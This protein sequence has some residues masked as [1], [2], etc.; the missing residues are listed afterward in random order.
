MGRAW[1]IREALEHDPGEP[2]PPLSGDLRTDVVIVGGGFTGLWTA[3]FL[4]EAEPG[5]RTAILEQDI[6][7]GGPSGRN[8]GFVTGWWD[9]LPGLVDL[10][11]ERGALAACRAL[12]S[13]VA[14]VGLWCER[15]GVD[16]WY[17]R[18]GYIT[19]ACAPGQEG[20]ADASVR[21]ANALGARDELTPMSAEEVRARCASPVF[22]SGV[23]M[24]DG[25][26]VQPARLARGLRRVALES[27]VRIFEGTP[28]RR[29][30]AGPPARA[31]TPYG[32]VT[33]DRAVVAVGAWAAAWPAFRR[34]L[35]TWTSFIVLTAPAPER[36]AA[37]G[38]TGGECITDA[39]TTVQYFRTTPDGRIAFGGGG[40]RVA[41]PRRPGLRWSRDPVSIGRAEAG[42]RRLFPSFAGV[43]VEDAWGG[44]IDVSPTHLP[45]FGTM[46]SGNVHYGFG[47]TGNGVAPSLL[48]GRI[49][50]GLVL[51]KDDEAT[52]LPMVRAAPRPFPPEPIKTIGA[53]MVREATVRVERREDEGRRVPAFLRAAAGLPRRVGYRLGAE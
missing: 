39:R 1:W 13:A 10:Y 5:L 21:L 43:P 11:G 16:A 9:E 47:Y 30:G 24:R 37:I 42:L 44:P 46:P 49:L 8:G 7:G 51:G 25:A 38:W 3:C 52:S 15:H 26:T 18:S 40:G 6:C 2:C 35:A 36:L 33:A 48:G 17:T 12:S 22:G 31:E 19:T 45:W 14:D 53:H 41:S 23:V 4:M 34:R 32:M 27:G 29:F 20:F 28:V 50:S